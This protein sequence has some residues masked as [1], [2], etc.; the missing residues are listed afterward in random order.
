MNR[1]EI[2]KLAREAGYTG[3]DSQSERLHEF[4]NLIIE[5]TRPKPLTVSQILDAS[6]E[7]ADRITPTGAAMWTEEFARAVERR[8]GVTDATE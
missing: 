2:I 5:A 1:D 8:L 3:Y 7:A 6:E 4:A